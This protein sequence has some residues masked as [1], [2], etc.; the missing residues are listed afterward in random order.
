[1]GKYGDF[2][3]EHHHAING[4]INYFDWAM[5]F[6]CFLMLFVCLPEGSMTLL[7]FG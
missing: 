5:A 6:G 7:F 3:I 4:S 2:N 1:M